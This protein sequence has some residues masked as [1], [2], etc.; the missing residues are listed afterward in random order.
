MRRTPIRPVKVPGGTKTEF[1]NIGFVASAFSFEPLKCSG[2]ID[3][4]EYA[5]TL[6]VRSGTADVAIGDRDE[7]KNALPEPI[8]AEAG[9]VLL[10]P[11]DTCYEVAAYGTSDT[12]VVEHR[13]P[14]E[15]AFQ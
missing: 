1:G 7:F 14:W 10:L 8:R 5:V 2:L 4:C 13:L 6:H 15:I 12:E 3:S 9:D 11:R